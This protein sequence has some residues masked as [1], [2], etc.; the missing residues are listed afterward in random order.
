MRIFPDIG[1]GGGTVSQI[2]FFRKKMS[3]LLALAVDRGE[4]GISGISPAMTTGRGS[5]RNRQGR[6]SPLDMQYGR[7]YYLRMGRAS[8]RDSI[9]GAGLKVMV[10]KGYA[11]AGV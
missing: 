10:R 11:G 5:T 3:V 9:L 4:F 1:H 8:L 2:L 6:Q 7:T